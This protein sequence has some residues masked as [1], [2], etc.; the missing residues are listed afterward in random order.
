MVERQIRITAVQ[1]IEEIL[2][3]VG[4]NLRAW[5]NILGLGANDVSAEQR[6]NRDDVSLEMTVLVRQNT[7]TKQEQ[8]LT[9]T[10]RTQG[11]AVSLCN[12]AGTR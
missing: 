8:A 1:Q 2:N 6:L 5:F 10:R 9:T 4:T 11:S 3:I 12:L 7:D